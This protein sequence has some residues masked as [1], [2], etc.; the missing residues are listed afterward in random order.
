M[1]NLLYY[2]GV[3]SRHNV[4][5]RILLQMRDLGHMLADNG[6][7]LRSGGAE[8][9]DSAFE[10]GAI[11]GGGGRQI[12]RPEFSHRWSYEILKI[13]T[14]FHYA[15]IQRVLPQFEYMKPIVQKL[16]AR[17]IGEVLGEDGSNPSR[18]VICYTPDGCYSRQTSTPD[19]GGTRTAI[20][21]AEEFGI[22]VFNL[23]NENALLQL[24]QYLNFNLSSLLTS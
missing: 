8:G 5:N 13:P 11:C 24:A 6:F 9:S 17:N 7:R 21:V 1:E 23:K 14:E 10:L 19:T 15:I 4:P 12:W 2:T 3:G 16:H 18:F 20:F 22:P